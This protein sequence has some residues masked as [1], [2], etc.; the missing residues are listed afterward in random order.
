MRYINL[1][2]TYLLTYLLLCNLQGWKMQVVGLVLKKRKYEIAWL[3]YASTKNM[4]TCKYSWWR[5]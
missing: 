4:S 2:F 3:E 1:H 5:L